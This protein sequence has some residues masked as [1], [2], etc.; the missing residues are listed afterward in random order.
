MYEAAAPKPSRTRPNLDRLS[1]MLAE[2]VLTSLQTN[3]SCASARYDAELS[4]DDRA[5]GTELFKAVVEYVRWR[6]M[7]VYGVGASKRFGK[8]FGVDMPSV[9]TPEAE[10]VH[11]MLN[12][13]DVFVSPTLAPPSYRQSVWPYLERVVGEIAVNWPSRE[14]PAGFKPSA[15]NEMVWKRINEIAEA[16]DLAV[17][18]STYQA[19][20]TGAVAYGATTRVF[21]HKFKTATPDLLVRE[22][23]FLSG[24]KPE[25]AGAWKTH[26]TTAFQSIRTDGINLLRQILDAVERFSAVRPT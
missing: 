9:P 10:P 20:L 1:K 26:K 18:P 15:A 14:M 8:A 3:V 12:G 13:R 16:T 19:S 2:H 7:I 4:R 6:A 22:D 24:A 23:V 17:D 21:R 25:I 5:L 11:I